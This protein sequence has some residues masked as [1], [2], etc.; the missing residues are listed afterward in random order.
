MQVVETEH[1]AKALL[2]Q[3]NGL[4]RRIVAKA[5]GDPS[6]LLQKLDDFIRRQPKVQGTSSQARSV[7]IT[8][9]PGC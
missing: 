4:A 2:E 3:P 7:A 6:A 5:G 9:Y 8:I 1:L